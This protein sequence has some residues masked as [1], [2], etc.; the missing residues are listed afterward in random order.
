[1]LDVI[2]TGGLPTVKPKRRNLLDFQFFLLNPA[3]FATFFTFFSNFFNFVI[4]IYP[5]RYAM[6]LKGE[7]LSN[8]VNILRNVYV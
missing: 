7:V 6:L 8:G 2:S 3:P 5:L 1:M 4:N